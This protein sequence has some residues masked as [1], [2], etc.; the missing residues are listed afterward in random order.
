MDPST[1]TTC[2]KETV[3]PSGLNIWSS[4]SA[5]GSA[6]EIDIIL[7]QGLGAHPFYTWVKKAPAPEVTAPR[8][9]RD[10]AKVWKR[11]TRDRNG[12]GSSAEVMWPRDLLVPRFQNARIATYSYK[13]D[14]KDRNVKTSLRECAEQ[15]LNV[16]FQ[17]RQHEHERQRPLVLI[18]HS[19]GGLVIQQALVIAVH[20]KPFADIR[21]SVGGIIFLGAPFQGSDVAVYGKWLAQVGGLDPTLLESLVKDCPSLH[22]LSRD[23]WGSYSNW[24]IVCFYE[25]K[26]FVCGPWKTR[27]VDAQSASLLGE[28]MMYL[29]T[30]HSGLN[31]FSGEDD[32]NYALLLPEIERIVREGPSVV[33][34]RHRRNDQYDSLGNKHWMVPR[35]LNTL[36]TGRKD[37]LGRIQNAFLSDRPSDHHTQR[38][39]VI[40]GLGGLG[41]SEVTLHAANLMREEFWGIFWVDVDTPSLAESAFINVAKKIGSSSSVDKLQ[42]ALQVLANTKKSWLLILDNADDPEFDYQK[43]LPSGTHGA[44][45]IT[46]RVSECSQ[47]NTVGSEALLGLDIPDAKKLLLKSAKIHEDLLYDSHAEEV[48]NLLGSH[49]LALIQAGAYIANGHSRLEEYPEVYKRQRKRLLEYKPKQG[50]SRYCNVYATF[51]ASAD[52]LERSNDEAAKD[53]LR[54]LE[55][56]SM[57]YSGSL[58]MQ[59]FEDAWTGC[60]E[61]LRTPSVETRDMD[62]LSRE[63][64][65]RLPEFISTPADAW[66]PYRLIEASSLLASLSLVTKDSSGLSMHPLTH[67]W[68]KDRQASDQQGHSWISTGCILALSWSESTLSQSEERQLRPQVQSY[69]DIEVNAAFSFGPETMVIPIFLQCGW[70][71][72]KM[73]DD[74]RLGHL[75]DDLFAKLHI[76][77]KIPSQEYLPIYNLEARSLY[78]LG[79]HERA[80]KLLEQ[81]VKIEETL[82]EDH[83]DRLASQHELARAY[84]ANGQI[85][86]AVKLLEHVIKIEGTSLAEDHPSRLASQQ[87]LASAYQAN[88]QVKEAAVELLE[89][90]VKIKRTTLAED[91]PDRLASQH[92]LAYAYQA[93]GQVKEAVKLLEHVVKIHKITL[94]EDHPDRLVSQH[95]LA[96]AYKATGQ[97]PKAVELLEHVVKIKRTALEED[98]PDRLAS[99]HAL[100]S[101]Y[102]ANGQVK[103]AIKLLEHVVKIRKITLAEDHPDRLVS[104]HE[105]ARAYKANG[106]VPKAAVEL[107]EH[108][109]KIRRS[110]LSDN[111]PDRIVSEEWLAYCLGQV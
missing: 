35:A 16:L 38:T 103:E 43:Y 50:Q 56:L 101:A 53:A 15:L 26:D 63:H 107:L 42:D 73:R 70:I 111:H 51:E 36:F 37:L 59:I 67:A 20:Q 71:L 45:I 44:V 72:D 78:N 28:R 58:P 10:K 30:D 4:E 108:V 39:F 102:Q 95:E 34:N 99:Q 77:P 1:H 60:R 8:R 83:P 52:I 48:V 92:A 14:W 41:K 86:E 106:Q 75:L 3:K 40:T 68:A 6:P 27:F 61:I 5:S 74:S 81:I 85:S 31:K 82:A 87:V 105:L 79:R 90:V 17:H 89:H 21:R 84:E 24:D 12:E 96:I 97:A 7:V 33:L 47:Y 64:I 2:T 49:T 76:D 65:S 54:L 57:L 98:H 18:G 22:A 9:L 94:A 109:V 55:V 93:N 46:S 23:F 25:N 110:K 19:F 69:L 13:S 104:Q 91:H 80:V 66:D 32:S 11:R 29:N 100:A 88:G 62:S